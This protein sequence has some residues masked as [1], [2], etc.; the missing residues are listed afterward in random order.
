MRR[1]MLFVGS[2][3]WEGGLLWSEVLKE[4]RELL[5]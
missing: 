2:D 1:T 4:L 5:R 3:C